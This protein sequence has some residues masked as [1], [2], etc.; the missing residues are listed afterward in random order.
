ML[1]SRFMEKHIKPDFNSDQF[2]VLKKAIDAHQEK[3][4]NPDDLLDKI[5][6]QVNSYTMYLIEE[7]ILP[8]RIDIIEG[9]KEL[10]KCQEFAFELEQHL[11]GKL[12]K[13]K[14]IKEWHRRLP[15]IKDFLDYLE[16]E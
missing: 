14:L 5:E 2:L 7:V 15:R 11:T 3:P 12:N 4:L 16:T 1:D 9:L 10:Y 6:I 13:R 8:G